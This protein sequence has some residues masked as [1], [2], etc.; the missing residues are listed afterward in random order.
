MI[1]MRIS[2]FK[3][4]IG[5][6]PTKYHGS[7]AKSDKKWKSV[8]DRDDAAGIALR[9]IFGDE[10]EVCISRTD[11]RILA[12]E[13]NLERFV[14]ATLLWGYPDG[15]RGKHVANI[16]DHI[17]DLTSLLKETRSTE[18]TDWKKYWK[19]VKAIKGVALST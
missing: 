15:M 9:S 8:L 3:N 6:M 17:G 16:C 1:A 11:L 7:R 18:I 4:L 12:K 10:K 19:Q 13:E 5:A 2:D 14:M